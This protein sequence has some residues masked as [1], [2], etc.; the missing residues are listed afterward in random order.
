MLRLY[1]YEVKENKTEIIIATAYS[2]FKNPKRKSC[3]CESRCTSYGMKT[4]ASEIKER[5]ANNYLIINVTNRKRIQGI[6][7]VVAF[8]ILLEIVNHA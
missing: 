7:I 2:I 1:V 8:E 4:G 6:G 5:T 3:L